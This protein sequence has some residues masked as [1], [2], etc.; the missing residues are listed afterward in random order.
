MLRM[1]RLALVAVFA[2]ASPIVAQDYIV[3][4]GDRLS[5]SVL[6]DPGLNREVLV[7]PDGRISMPLAGTLNAAGQ[8][9]EQLQA[10]IRSRLSRDFVTPPTVTVSLVALGNPEDADEEGLTTIYILGQ[11]R[12]PGVYQVLPPSDLLHALAIAGGPDAFA[13]R[14]R[15]QVRRRGTDGEQVFLFDYDAVESGLAPSPQ[16]LLSDGDVIIVPERRLFE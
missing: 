10:A 15:I 16:I 1:L 2:A 9:P 3:Q 6:E 4:P 8:T 12:Q 5:V 7:R 11:V 14:S 13:A